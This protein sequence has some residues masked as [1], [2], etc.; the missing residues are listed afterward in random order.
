M[1]A[2]P[3]PKAAR[4]KKRRRAPREE[5]VAYVVEITGWDWGY[6]L[7]LDTSKDPDD[8]YHEFRHLQITGKM[9]R[10]AGLKTDQVEISLLP[11]L[12]MSE[13]RRK[14][15]KPI[16][17]GSPDTYPDMI[18]GRVG[19]PADVLSPILQLLIAKE[20]RFLLM[21]G[22]KFRYRSA[23]LHGCRLEMKLTEDDMP[24]AEGATG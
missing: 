17:V 13:E 14:D 5:F 9:L 21:T 3:K 10:P 2:E 19:I 7:S 18:R 16:A 24:T 12:S 23:R 15:Y 11:T 6:S 4:K 1:A 20:L 8:P 22:S